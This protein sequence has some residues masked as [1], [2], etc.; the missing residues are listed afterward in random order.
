MSLFTENLDDKIPRKPVGSA[1][2]LPAIPS[3]S[4]DIDLS[5]PA[6]T[7]TM[8]DISPTSSKT[9]VVKRK[10]VGSV[11]FSGQWKYYVLKYSK[12]IYMTTNPDAKHL[13]SPVAPSHYVDVN[14]ENQS[15]EFDIPKEG[16]RLLVDRLGLSLLKDGGL[17]IN[18]WLF[19]E[20][21]M[22]YYV[23][24]AVNTVT[25]RGKTYC[26]STRG[27]QYKV[28]I[29]DETTVY[30]MMN[31]RQGYRD[32]LGGKLRGTSKYETKDEDDNH[33]KDTIGWMYVYQ[34]FPEPD[35]T[36]LIATLLF[37]AYSRRW[38]L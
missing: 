32:A 21:P 29:Y 16:M 7:V 11:L 24:Y 17:L 5:R 1:P 38:T 3:A 33:D 9:K 13:T 35:R 15:L 12:D 26:I 28:Y 22:D 30:C 23:N 19:S 6:S 8:G 14:I 34:Q 31:L 25:V 4:S 18:K 36:I 10:P 27:F 37:F 2:V 20:Q